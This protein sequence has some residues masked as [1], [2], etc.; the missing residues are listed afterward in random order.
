MGGSSKVYLVNFLHSII[1]VVEIEITESGEIIEIA[2]EATEAFQEEDMELYDLPSIRPAST[3][4]P[5]WL[6][7]ID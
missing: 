4:I 2:T 5:P 6:F 3:I 1:L 7:G